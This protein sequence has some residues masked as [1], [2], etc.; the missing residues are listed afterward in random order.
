[1]IAIVIRLTVLGLVTLAAGATLVASPGQARRP[2]PKTQTV[3]TCAA[4]LGMGTA[5]RRRFCDVIIATKA[6]DSITMAIPA[7]TGAATLLFDLHPR[8]DVPADD[9]EPTMA[10]ARHAAIVSVIRATGAVVER[11]VVV[12]EFRT[13]ADLFDRIAG[14]KLVA[15]GRPEAIKITIP[16]GVPSIGIVGVKLQ[17]TRRLTTASY[18]ASGRPIAVVSNLRVEYIPSR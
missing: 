9:V 13:V 7:H 16:A 1:L 3:F 8:I 11:A 14:V 10:F 18:E 17:V 6:G 2:P 5:S 4:E 15:P 12:K